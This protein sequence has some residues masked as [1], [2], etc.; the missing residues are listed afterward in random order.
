MSGGISDRVTAARVKGRVNETVMR[1]AMMYGLEIITLCKT[2][3]AELRVPKLKTL[4]IYFGGTKMDR[5]RNWH[6]RLRSGS[7]AKQC[8]G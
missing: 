5:S 1:P 2:Q 3:E 7:L 4:R 6:I 8:L